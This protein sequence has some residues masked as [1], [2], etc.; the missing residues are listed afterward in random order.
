LIGRSALII[1]LSGE[2]HQVP[3]VAVE[4]LQHR[5]AAAPPAIRTRSGIDL[6]EGKEKE[7]D[8]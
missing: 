2:M 1:A 4:I 3:Q 7:M 8:A 5:D 6:L